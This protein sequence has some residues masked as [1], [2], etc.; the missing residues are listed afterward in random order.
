MIDD[1]LDGKE[2]AFPEEEGG[3]P[4]RL[5]FYGEDTAPLNRE[6]RS[7]MARHFRLAGL[8]PAWYA[9]RPLNDEPYRQFRET[10]QAE[11]MPCLVA[12]A[13]PRHYTRPA[14]ARRWFD[15]GTYAPLPAL[16][17]RPEF[18]RAGLNDP[19][20][21]FRVYGG[22]C[23]V[24]LVDMER[25][26]NRPPPKGWADLFDPRYRQ[27]IMVNG[28]EDK[29]APMLLANLGRDFGTARLERLGHNL[30]AVRLPS[31]MARAAG[32]RDP[33][34]AA[35]NVLPWFWAENNIHKDNAVVVWPE[36]GAY[37]TPMLMFGKPHLTPGAAAAF[38]FLTGASW[39][40]RMESICCPVAGSRHAH[41]PLPGELRW[42]GWD[43]LRSPDLDAL[44]FEAGQ[45]CRKGYC[46]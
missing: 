28:Q 3:P 46:Q 6:L 38:D 39:A 4:R 17:T 14:F 37:C 31:E 26:G 29:P 40:E 36:E 43:M 15:G 21:V 24:I 7:Q 11:D 32:S 2:P 10:R 35:I 1:G 8:S 33:N 22:T 27:D 23:W 12:A 30:K 20:D 41:P 45:R 44:I 9:P 34:R 18:V 16:E 13:N 19:R 5:D 25:L 42:I